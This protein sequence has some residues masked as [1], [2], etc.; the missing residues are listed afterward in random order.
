MCRYSIVVKQLIT[1]FF[2]FL[3]AG[4]TLANLFLLADYVVRFNAFVELCENKDRPELEC[5]GKC[6]FAKV[7]NSHTEPEKPQLNQIIEV[8]LVAVF[9]E[10]ENDLLS[11]EEVNSNTKGLLSNDVIPTCLAL[12]IP[13][14]PP[15]LS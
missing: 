6:Q 14:P 10:I 4:T 5:D 15:K 3:V 2:A 1:Y 13:T 9:F 8:V 11:I 12:G 7:M